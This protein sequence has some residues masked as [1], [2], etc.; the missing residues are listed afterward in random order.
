M[1]SFTGVKECQR[2]AMRPE[3]GIESVRL[4]AMDS[5]EVLSSEVRVITAC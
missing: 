1:I 2:S 5:V 4:G 3:G